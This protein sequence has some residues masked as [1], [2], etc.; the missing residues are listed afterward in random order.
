MEDLIKEVFRIAY[1]LGEYDNE[2][3]SSD[4]SWNFDKWKET[5]DYKDLVKKHSRLAF[6]VEQSVCEP[7]ECG[8]EKDNDHRM[9][10]TC[11]KE[12]HF[13]AN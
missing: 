9:C 10:H 1:S 3:N 5:E 4:N 12:K 2:F 8:N 13:E 11:W 6:V 7:C